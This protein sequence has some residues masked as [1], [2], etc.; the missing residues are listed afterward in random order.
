[1]PN[2]LEIKWADYCCYWYKQFCL[3]KFEKCFWSDLGGYPINEE[4]QFYKEAQ[5]T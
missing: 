1:M 5:K 4:C 3:L 2:N